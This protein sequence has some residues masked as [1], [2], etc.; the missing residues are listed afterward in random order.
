[1]RKMTEIERAIIAEKTLVGR[2]NIIPSTLACKECGCTRIRHYDRVS[3]LM[4]PFCEACEMGV[5]D[6]INKFF[7][8][9]ALTSF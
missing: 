7:L 5:T 9:I 6:E 8:T 4:L 3:S 1:M 2:L